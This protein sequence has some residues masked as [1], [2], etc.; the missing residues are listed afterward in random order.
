MTFGPCTI[1]RISVM[2]RQC[3]NI[4]NIW[5]NKRDIF[6]THNINKK[7]NTEKQTLDSESQNAARLYDVA[8]PSYGGESARLV[9]DLQDDGRDYAEVLFGCGGERELDIRMT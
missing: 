5:E 7:S 8:S 1:Y 3:V 6:P 9:G 2:E 4:L